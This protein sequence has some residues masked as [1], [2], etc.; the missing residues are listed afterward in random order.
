MLPITLLQTTYMLKLLFHFVTML[1]LWAGYV[2][3]QKPLGKNWEKIPFWLKIPVLPQ[4]PWL[5]VKKY[6]FLVAKNMAGNDPAVSL[7][8]SSSVT[9]TNV[10]IHCWTV[11]T[12]LACNTT[13]ILS[14][15]Q[16]DSQV[17]NLWCES[18]IC[19]VYIALW[20]VHMWT[21]QWF[22]NISCWHC[23]FWW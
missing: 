19:T 8:K 16:C 13:T 18:D 21:C 23:A 2:S 6:Q 5:L 3:P 4:Q 1:C 9:L 12:A 15:S 7:K 17:V 11:V 22:P 20:I 10:E 14:T